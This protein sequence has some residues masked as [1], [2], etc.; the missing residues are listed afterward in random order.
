[1]SCSDRSNEISYPHFFLSKLSVE[2]TIRANANKIV[3]NLA[4]LLKSPSP[5]QDL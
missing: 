2:R 1:M 4:A 3:D 5:N